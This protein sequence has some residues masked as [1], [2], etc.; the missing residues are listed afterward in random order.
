MESTALISIAS[1]VA[2]AAIVSGAVLFLNGWRDRR[3]RRKELLFNL[4]FKLADNLM[5]QAKE[6]A[7]TSS[8]P[9]KVKDTIFYAEEYYRWIDHMYSN[10]KLPKE[11]YDKMER[12]NIS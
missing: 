8:R 4:S 5:D 7:K 2:T 10:G 9:I 11:A 12:S 3:T 6:K 1:S